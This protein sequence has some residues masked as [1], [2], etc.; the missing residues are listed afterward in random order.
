ME[1]DTGG[2]TGWMVLSAHQQFLLTDWLGNGDGEIKYFPK[3]HQLECNPAWKV[4]T[5]LDNSLC[6]QRRQA[7]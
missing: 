5:P 2:T 3:H 7:E 6:E 1:M 4:R